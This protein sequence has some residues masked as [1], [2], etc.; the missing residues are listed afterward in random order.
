MRAI[1]CEQ[2][3]AITAARKKASDTMAATWGVESS[4]D[5]SA[6]RPTNRTTIDMIQGTPYH[7]PAR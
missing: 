1:I 5:H 6:T 4:E 7:D 2:P 3:P